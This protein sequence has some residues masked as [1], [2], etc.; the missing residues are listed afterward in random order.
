[1][2]PMTDNPPDER[3]APTVLLAFDARSNG[4]DEVLN[5]KR[6]Q[7]IMRRSGMNTTMFFIPCEYD[8]DRLTDRAKALIASGW[9]GN[10][11]TGDELID[12]PLWR[13]R[14]SAPLPAAAETII[15]HFGLTGEQAEKVRSKAR[16]IAHAYGDPPEGKV[17]RYDWST[18]PAPVSAAADATDYINGIAEAPGLVAC[19]DAPEYV[20]AAPWAFMLTGREVFS[21]IPEEPATAGA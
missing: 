9:R 8:P 5:R 12:T 21:F 13:S 10:A 20:G 19:G 11:G 4:V 15:R 3:K 7:R 2:I 16:A 6:N 17:E 1:M 18:S 14:R